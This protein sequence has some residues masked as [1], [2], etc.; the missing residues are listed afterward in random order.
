MRC[1]NRTHEV[2]RGDDGRDGVEEDEELWLF[3]N[4]SLLVWAAWEA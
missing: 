3:E 4:H 2:H 1:R